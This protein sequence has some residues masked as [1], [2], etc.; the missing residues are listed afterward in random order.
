MRETGIQS[1]VKPLTH[2]H[3]AN[4]KVLL[5]ERKRHTARHV[6]SNP[7]VV[8]ARG[9]GGTPSQDR[10][11]HPHPGEPSIWT[12]TWLGYPPLGRDLGYPPERTWD[13]LKYYGMEMG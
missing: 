1:P 13:Q 9:R 3:K 10:G 6:A 4:K 7:S 5:Q 11:Y 2:D 12:W 8:L